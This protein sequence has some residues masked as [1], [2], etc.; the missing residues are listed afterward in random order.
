MLHGR[1]F[2][3]NELTVIASESYNSFASKL[4]TEITEAV[5]DRPIKVQSS[6]FTGMLVT[7]ARGEQKTLDEDDAQDVVFTLR[8]KGY[9]TK[10]GQLTQQFHDYKQQGTLDFGEDYNEYKADIVKRL[11]AVF[12]PDAVKPENARQIREAKF[13]SQKFERKEFQEMWKKINHQT[14]Y[15]VDFKTE[16]LIQHAVNELDNHLRVSEIN[17]QVTTGTLNEIKNKQEFTEG[18]AMKVT[19]TDTH[20]VKELVNENVKYDL[21]GKLVEATGLTRR[22]IVTILQK[23]SPSTFY[24]FRANP[25]EFIIKAGNIINQCKAIAVIE[26][27]A[28]H[29]L[30]KTFD[31]DIFSASALKGKLGVNAM[32]SQKSLYDLVVVDSQGIEMNFAQALEHQNEVIVYTK[33]SLSGKNRYN[34]ISTTKSSS[35]I[36][37]AKKGL[38]F[39]AV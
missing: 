14:Y 18:T 31:S 21:I 22:V 1:V 23:I 5:G 11:D 9:I 4:Q 38:S 34:P 37:F 35:Y 30:D 26:H 27:V 10:Q 28:Y 25:E 6:M 32:E 16:D 29:K 13:D 36:V 12:N 33:L 8:M 7:N 3:V 39:C 19:G 24:K 2:E 20:A 17:I 15:T